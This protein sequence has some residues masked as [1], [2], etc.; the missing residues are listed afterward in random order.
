MT[1]EQ[2]GKNTSKGRTCR[3]VLNGKNTS[4]PRGDPAG[5]SRTASDHLPRLW[6]SDADDTSQS[7]DGNDVAGS[8]TACLV[9]YSNSRNNHN[10]KGIAHMD[11]RMVHKAFSPS[12]CKL[13]VYS[14][15]C[16]NG[17]KGQVLSLS[18]PLRRLS[19]QSGTKIAL[20]LRELDLY[21][22]AIPEDSPG[23]SAGGSERSF[24]ASNL[25]RLRRKMGSCVGSLR[26]VGRRALA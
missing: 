6:Q 22:R 8:H 26:L 2:V 21:P 12:N 17:T 7:A 5:N 14:S 19:T 18:L 4:T 13:R 20:Y 10:R 3:E 23:Y 1:D 15:I 25:P 9:S 16:L 11:N 24:H